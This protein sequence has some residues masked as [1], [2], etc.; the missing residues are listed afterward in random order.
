ME[1]KFSLF[2]TETIIAKQG[3]SKLTRNEMSY[4]KTFDTLEEAQS[5]KKD[6]EE[7][8]IILLSY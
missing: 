6:Y 8:T 7:N 4:I 5:A 3:D 2:A 1:H